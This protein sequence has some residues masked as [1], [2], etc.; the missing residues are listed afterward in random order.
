MV[1]KIR[2]WEKKKILAII[3][4][5]IVS[6][7]LSSAIISADDS[8]PPHAIWGWAE[9][10][11]GGPA[12]DAEVEIVSVEGSV[13][14]TVF[15]DGAWQVDVGDPSPWPVDTPFTVS[16]IQK[17][18]Y[19]YNGWS[20]SQSGV[21]NSA[22]LQ[23]MGTM[24]LL[25]PAAPL[26]SVVDAPSQGL[27]GTPI[28]FEFQLNDT[29][30]LQTRLEIDFDGDGVVD[31][32]SDW[33]NGNQSVVVDHIYSATGMVTVKARCENA[34]NQYSPWVEHQLVLSSPDGWE[35][36]LTVSELGGRNDVV[37]FGEYADASDGQD[38][39]DVPHPPPGQ[40]PYLKAFFS[41]P[42][43]GIFSQLMKNY[44][45]F[46]INN[47][48]KIWN[49][50]MQ[51][52]PYDSA[53][54]TETTL[55]WNA[56][57][58]ADCEY[59]QVLL[60]DES[61]GVLADMLVEQ[62]YTFTQN[63]LMLYEFYI[64]CSQGA[65][66]QYLLNVSIE[67]SGSIVVDPDL[68]EYEQGSNVSIEAFADVG[69]RFSH[70]SG[71][72]SGALNPIDVVM[73]E[74]KNITAH[75]IEE[76]YTLSISMSGAGTGSVE[77]APSEPFLY[78]DVVTVWANASIA[79]FFAVWSGDLNGSSSP[80]TLV[81]TKNMS[82][83]AEFGLEAAPEVPVISGSSEVIHGQSASF[84]ANSTDPE[85]QQIWYLFDWGD[86]SNS[87][88]LGPVD[89]GTPYIESH[90]WM[91]PA[92]YEIHV[93]AKDSTGLESGWSNP[94]V[95]NVV[96]TPVMIHSPLPGDG[97][98][99]VSLNVF[100]N[101]TISDADGDSFTYSI[102][103]SNGQ[104]VSA[105]NESD[106]VKTLSLTGLSP[107][108][109]YTV[110]VNVSD[111]FDNSYE[112]YTFTTYHIFHFDL[113]SGWNY[114]TLPLQSP[115]VWASDLAALIDKCTMVSMFNAS[116]QSYES[117]IVNG[118]RRFDFSLEAGMGI[119]V[120]TTNVT[121]FDLT[122][123]PLESCSVELLPGWNAIGWFHEYQ[124]TACSLA[125][126]ISHCQMVSWFDADLQRYHSFVVDGPM[127]FDF[128]ISRGIGLF[129][130]VD[131]PSVW[132]GEG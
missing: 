64:V 99:G 73:D 106:G 78:G 101:V 48:E 22:A 4:L 54:P 39:S 83:D 75:F 61:R 132:F 116:S 49:L 29:N 46:D 96:N 6:S 41:T 127:S 119:V 84:S 60:M 93:K 66:Q 72:V 59:A 58:L 107:Q 121:S 76:I 7:V 8:R 81:M 79:S 114:I 77:Y 130:L 67:G 37:T 87:S 2:N 18:P 12:E 15:D 19:P 80:E 126:N 90:M 28:T 9:Y 32:T 104:S 3:G 21:I 82:I 51:W 44:Q 13:S 123:V 115:C 108:T 110:W 38:S 45:H 11:S 98:V 86:G 20:V 33:L 120:M 124:T 57:L 103:C 89:S 88:W 52:F 91:L 70:W 122:G 105:S 14:T 34:G 50:T 24:V 35:V 68:P 97:S 53:S 94:F 85:G 30:N 63:A 74:N 65:P 95:V 23:F 129:V 47:T 128:V 118:S 113:V 102:A 125:E 62:N 17:G 26:I 109:T 71:D 111:G 117:Y 5:L 112:V 16:I 10:E 131:E 55:S 69:W 31:D 25:P 100:W 40:P 42:F 1:I 43:D 92:Q 36:D 27:I 56:T